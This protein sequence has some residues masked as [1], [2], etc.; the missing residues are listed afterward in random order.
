MDLFNFSEIDSY[1]IKKLDQLLVFRSSI[2]IQN[3]IENK[4]QEMPFGVDIGMESG[5]CK[6]NN[7][8]RVRRVF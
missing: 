8:E 1:L 7:L 2:L 3:K 4:K 6:Q 5:F